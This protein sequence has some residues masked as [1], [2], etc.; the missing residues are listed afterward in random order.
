M[1]PPFFFMDMKRLY[2]FALLAL[3]ISLCACSKDDSEGSTDSGIVDVNKDPLSHLSE[4]EKKFLGYWH[5]NN[6][7]YDFKFFSDLTCIC[8]KDDGSD[9]ESGEWSYNETSKI[10]STTIGSYQWTITLSTDKSW[11]GLGLGTSTAGAVSFVRSDVS[12]IINGFLKPYTWR[13]SD[14]EIISFKPTY[15]MKYKEDKIEG[16][17]SSY[18]TGH[19]WRRLNSKFVSYLNASE[20]MEY[21]NIIIRN[22]NNSKGSLSATISQQGS[23]G[24]LIDGN[25]IY[26]DDYDWTFSGEMTI[27]N[28]SDADKQS[29]ARM[30]IKGTYNVPKKNMKYEL[31]VVY[32][33]AE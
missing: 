9:P 33:I 16:S 18:G 1:V 25:Y 2:F 7:S 3:C 5:N 17:Y 28:V 8:Y 20:Y 19:E 23:F 27:S 15:D 10:L 6:G 26:F 14:N 24:N 12:H 11:A 21:G 30:I 22:F 31:N 13:S 32:T 4:Q 29:D